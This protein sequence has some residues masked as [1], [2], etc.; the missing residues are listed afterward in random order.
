MATCKAVRQFPSVHR[1]E[2]G[3]GPSIAY[4]AHRRTHS[5]VSL[6]PTCPACASGGQTS[7]IFFAALSPLPVSRPSRQHC[8]PHSHANALHSPT[9]NRLPIT[10]DL[11]SLS[12]KRIRDYM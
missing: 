3:L 5:H 8:S 7:V 4:I 10:L 6:Q 9:P 11:A 1:D 2:G 12:P